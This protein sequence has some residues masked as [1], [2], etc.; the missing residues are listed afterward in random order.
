M[1]TFVSQ[2]T[3]FLEASLVGLNS[4]FALTVAG[5]HLTGEATIAWHD[6][7]GC[8]CTLL[9]EWGTKL[10]ERARP[11]AQKTI[12]GLDFLRLK[13]GSDEGMQSFV[14]KFDTKLAQLEEKGR[15]MLQFVLACPE[16]FRP[17]L[18]EVTVEG[19]EG[20]RQVQN[21]A[22][23]LAQLKEVAGAPMS[24]VV[25]ISQKSIKGPKSSF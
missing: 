12:T 21:R 4:D 14:H 2:L 23:M 22:I 17:D 9:K 13:K 10:V 24:R 7:V 11:V 8:R 18:L 16:S 19:S 5:L 3:R 25:D 20:L 6:P 15:P 1:E